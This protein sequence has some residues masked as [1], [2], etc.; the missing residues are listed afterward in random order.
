M[1]LE[2]IHRPSFKLF[3]VQYTEIQVIIPVLTNPEGRTGL[4]QA[5]ANVCLRRTYGDRVSNCYNG[6][7]LDLPAPFTVVRL[8]VEH[9]ESDWREN[10]ARVD[11][12]R[13]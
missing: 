13:S 1:C 9:T 3:R 8:R 2:F 7:E 5:Y 4:L 12:K 11:P 10:R 6:A